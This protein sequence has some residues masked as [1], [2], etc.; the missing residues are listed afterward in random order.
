M[1]CHRAESNRRAW[2]GRSHGETYV[3]VWGVGCRP[4]LVWALAERGLAHARGPMGGARREAD[5]RRG[6]QRRS[7]GE[8]D[9]GVAALVATNRQNQG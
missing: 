9:E 7:R 1:G 2:R 4:S 6:G 5:A 3:V 8:A